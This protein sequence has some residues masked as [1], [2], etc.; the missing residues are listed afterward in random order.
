MSATWGDLDFVAGP[1][2]IDF[3]NT[4]SWTEDGSL[5]RERLESF[6]SAVA[7][8]VRAKVLES[9]A[10][11]KLRDLAAQNSRAAE[12]ALGRLRR[13]RQDLADVAVSVA[14]GTQVPVEAEDDLARWFRE[15]QTNATLR[16]IKGRFYFDV[17][18]SANSLDTILWI[19]AQ[20]AL[21]VL[22]TANLGRLRRC[23]KDHCWWFFLDTS[24]NGRRR[25]CDMSSCGNIAKAR[26]YYAKHHPHAEA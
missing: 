7:W 14:A 22:T 13:F 3:V 26:R 18:K 24:K 2:S 17:T 12:L 21:R 16:Y 8:A 19:L 15:A 6:S 9:D 5:R 25:W 10:C 11:E 1:V 23:E 4:A 20:D